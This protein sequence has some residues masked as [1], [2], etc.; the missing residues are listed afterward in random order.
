M[1]WEILG[2]PTLCVKHCINIIYSSFLCRFPVSNY[3]RDLLSKFYSEP[4][5]TA[6]PRDIYEK[7]PL[8]AQARVNKYWSHDFI[9]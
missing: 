3:A 8:M 1:E 9:M 2:H 6:V 5:F 7:V 4:V